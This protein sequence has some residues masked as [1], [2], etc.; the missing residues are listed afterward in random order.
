M[1]EVRMYLE[2]ANKQGFRTYSHYSLVGNT[3]VVLYN[4]TSAIYPLLNSSLLFR[5]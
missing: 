4:V 1:M 3:N 2:G 5:S